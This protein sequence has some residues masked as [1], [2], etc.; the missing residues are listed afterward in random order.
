MF[1]REEKAVGIWLHVVEDD[2]WKFNY[3]LTPSVV[4]AKN[5]LW[6]SLVK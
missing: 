5:Q 1:L 6:V 4:F 2:L 3:S